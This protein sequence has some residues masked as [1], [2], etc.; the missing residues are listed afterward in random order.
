MCSVAQGAAF[1]KKIQQNLRYAGRLLIA[2]TNM[3]DKHKSDFNFVTGSL[4]W[5]P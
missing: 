2:A 4:I 5:N 3:L 1:A